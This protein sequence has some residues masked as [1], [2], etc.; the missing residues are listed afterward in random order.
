MKTS[1]VRA[2]L[3]S[4]SVVCSAQMT[5][6]QKVADFQQLAAVYAKNYGPYEW[7]VASQGFDLLNLKPWLDRVRQSKDDLEFQELCIEYVASL[8][9]A[10]DLVAFPSDF[11]ASLGFTV[12]IY[13]GRVLIDSINRIRLPAASFPFVIGD[14]LVSVDGQGVEEL[15]RAFSKYSVSANSR[16]TRRSAAN[17]IT[18]RSQSVMPHAHEIGDSAIVVIQRQSGAMETYTIPWL[19]NGTPITAEGPVPSPRSAAVAEREMTLDSEDEDTPEYMR[20]LLRLWNVTLPE[21]RWTVLGFGSRAPIF[22]LP[23]GFTQRLGRVPSDVF[24][25]GIFEGAGFKIGFLRIPNFSQ[26]AAGS[27]LQQ[28]ESEIKFMQENTDG[29]IIDDTRNPG[30]NACYDEALLARV[31]PYRF[32]TLGFE[33]RA[34]ANWV[35]SFSS[36]LTLARLQGA[37]QWVIDIYQALLKDV[38]TAY[39]ENRGRTGP[40]PLCGPESYLNPAVDRDGNSVAYS[41]PLMVLVDEFSASGGDLFPAVIQDNQRGII[42][43]MRTMGAGGNVIGFDGTSYSEAFARVTASLMNRKDP[44]VTPDN[45][46]APYVE[47]IGVRPDRTQD[48]MTRENLLNNGRAFVEAFV[49]A[50]VEHIQRN[51]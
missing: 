50:M 32:R 46:T 9:D 39:A 8:N 7:K 44:V 1:I 15:I 33:V 14:E 35:A 4:I 26:P 6:D 27:A 16:S 24:Y 11:S 10:H 51:L 20:A 42:F 3:V 38:K 13:D 30:G 23:A 47:N 28:F 5:V 31:I 22:A 17:R 34:T 25:S 37:P 19:K 12:D 2:L 21:E 45:P 40:L 36:S 49:N 29:L 41:K 43:G 48:Y 18:T